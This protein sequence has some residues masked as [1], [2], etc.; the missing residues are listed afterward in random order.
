MLKIKKGD[1]VKVIAGKEKDKEGKVLCLRIVLRL[2]DTH[3]DHNLV[4]LGNF[5]DILIS[6][7]LDHSIYD[8]VFIYLFQS[9]HQS[10]PPFLEL[11]NHFACCLCE[12]Y[13]LISI[14]LKANPW[15]KIKKGDT[16]K[17]IAGKEKDKEGKVLS[18]DTKNGKVLV[19]GVNMATKHTKPSAANQ[20]GGI[21]PL[22]SR[23]RGSARFTRRSRNSYI[24]SPRS[25]TLH[26]I[27][28]PSRIL[29][30]A[31]AFFAFVVTTFCPVMI[32]MSFTS[33]L[34]QQ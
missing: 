4:K 15:L 27:A 32:S 5:H 6:K 11:I 30:L 8:L 26:P 24:F 33:W 20:T 12:T 17:V 2:T 21:I 31:I 16:V 22:K 18:V 28:I 1:T 34:K 25:V 3:V 23:T 19:E 10:G 14:H 29:K 13:F 9:T 7:L